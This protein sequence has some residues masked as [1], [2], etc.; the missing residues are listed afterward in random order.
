MTRRAHA[1][2]CCSW[3]R[4]SVP[5]CCWMEPNSVD[6][7][8]LICIRRCWAAS[9]GRSFGASAFASPLRSPTSISAETS[10]AI[11]A[12]RQ[13]GSSFG[14][15]RSHSSASFGKSGKLWRC[16]CSIASWYC[17][18]SVRTSSFTPLAYRLSIGVRSGA[19]LR[20]PGPP[21][22]T[23]GATSQPMQIGFWISS[24]E[25]G[26][27]EMV[28]AAQRAE[29]AG[30]PYVQL[31]D[32]FHPWIDRQGQ[33]PFVWSVIG[34]IAATTKLTVGTGVTCPII[35]IHPAIVAQAAATSAVMLDGRFFLGVGTG[36]NLNE[37]VVGRGW[38]PLETRR[39][40]LEEA[41]DVLRL[42]FRGGERSFRGTYFTVEDARLY[43]I[44]DQPPPIYIAAGGPKMAQIAGRIGDGLISTKP[45]REIVAK[46]EG[47]GGAGKPR[48]IE[49]QLCWGRDTAA[50]RTSKRRRSRSRWR[51]R[52]RTCRSDPTP[53][54][55]CARS[56][57]APMPGSITSVCIRSART[58]RVSLRSG[59]R[60]CVQ[61]WSGS[62]PQSEASPLSVQP[63]LVQHVAERFADQIAAQV[64]AEDV[65]DPRVFLRDR[66]RRMRAED[67]VRH[68]PEWRARR[69]WLV[70]QDVE[71]R[72]GQSFF[73]QRSDQRV[74]VE[75][76]AAADVD[77]HGARPKL[78]ELAF[79]DDA[80][81][82]GRVW[83]REHEEVGLAKH[84]VEL[85]TVE[86]PVGTR[87][88]FIGSAHSGHAHVHPVT[89]A[90]D[91]LAD[92]AETDDRERL[93]SQLLAAVPLPS[94][95][96]FVALHP[97][98]VLREHEHRHQTEVGERAGVDAT[99]GRERDVGTVE[100][101]APD[102]LADPGAGRLKPPQTQR[103]GR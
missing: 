84:R 43:T 78:S 20:S 67:H 74:L 24:E 23:L 3:A 99:R 18:G 45:D 59:K 7:C 25:H 81:G 13:N 6:A 48:C 36:E 27:L 60:S 86:Q 22:G 2:S 93:P 52:P 103:D 17:L 12:Q 69:R 65:G 57:N 85:G 1:W 5:W 42:L 87:H 90:C 16:Q 76:G 64:L 66:A 38:P 98:V 82:L 35:R 39:E 30:F 55:I 32:H 47:A 54:P 26:P 96:L 94:L 102:E 73:L 88:W 92:T 100:A 95:R 50:P 77:H 11:F 10:S 61:C 8:A 28:R 49:V 34:A 33:S 68:L 9:S 51:R 97:H 14:K 53:S 71:R 72:A 75:E 40:M 62:A 80:L 29:Q 31:S 89:V 101:D 21:C 70:A 46:F 91:L 4:A 19:R 15:K 56:R 37:H 44:P 63:L 41:I 58:R 83:R 79:A